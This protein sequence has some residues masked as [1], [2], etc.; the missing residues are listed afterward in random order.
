LAEEKESEDQLAIKR[1]NCSQIAILFCTL[2]FDCVM[3]HDNCP[4]LLSNW[5]STNA[6]TDYGWGKVLRRS[7]EG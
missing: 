3:L 2:R 6:L 5:S 7:R 4:L 1:W